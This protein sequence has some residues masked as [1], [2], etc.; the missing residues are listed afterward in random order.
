LTA[1]ALLLL[2]EKRACFANANPT[3]KRSG[4]GH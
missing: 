2:V 1:M 3:I 4:S